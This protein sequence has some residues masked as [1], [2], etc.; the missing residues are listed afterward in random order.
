MREI[1]LLT[2][3]TGAL[4][5]ELL[6]MLLARG[7]HVVCLSRGCGGAS[8]QE[9][10][11]R[12]IGGDDK[13]E[14]IAGDI[15][16]PQCGVGTDEIARLKGRVKIIHAAASISFN[17]R[18][19]SEVE[20]A[21]VRGVENI[22]ALADALGVNEFHHVSTAYVCGDTAEFSE[23]DVPE[24]NGANEPRNVYEE[25][26]Q[27]GE[28]LVR[29]WASFA[30]SIRRFS[31]Y[32]PSIL[33]GRQDG[34]TPTYDA[35]YGWFK[36]IHGIAEMMRAKHRAGETLPPDVSIHENGIVDI[37]LVLFASEDS[38]LNLVPIDWVADLI[39]KLSSL[40]V[41]NATYH[42]VNPF[43]PL[44]RWV[45]ATSLARLKVRSG[46]GA[47]LKVVSSGT[48]KERALAAQSPLV[49][50]LQRKLALV[51]DQYDPYTS[52][53]PH[54]SAARARAVLGEDFRLFRTVDAAF[55]G[56]LLEYA[57]R[58]NWGTSPR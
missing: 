24:P 26:K 20:A 28:A 30:P 53:G 44:V 13:V 7:E 16:E 18:D 39:A 23:N 47:R 51:L 38:T 48:E 3:A 58:T 29:T 21:N 54:F 10:V 49:A 45:I 12:I 25:T 4:G 19:R 11:K 57:L 32:R 55:L 50:R 36:P 8:P 43:P 17:D 40:A 33:I 41:E 35:Y 2:G 6:K 22:L 52:I 5:G 27:K 31:I 14:V 34:M 37:P 9:R 56:E 1:I 42:L 15:C 46:E